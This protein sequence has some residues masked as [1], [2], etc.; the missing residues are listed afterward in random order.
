M[1]FQD[2]D[3]EYS[4]SSDRGVLN[5]AHPALCMLDQILRDLEKRRTAQPSNVGYDL[6]F[7]TSVEWAYQERIAGAQ[8]SSAG[9][10]DYVELSDR[11][12]VV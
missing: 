9:G 6:G 8:P 7:Q 2:R 3:L 4:A 5:T 10:I 11:K 12:S 1:L